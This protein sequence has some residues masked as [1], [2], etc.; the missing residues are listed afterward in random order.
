MKSIHRALPLIVAVMTCMSL[1]SCNFDR[2]LS[3]LSWLGFHVSEN[4]EQPEKSDE[5][6]TVDTMVA[7]GVDV[8][9]AAANVAEVAQST[10]ATPSGDIELEGKINGKYGVHMELDLD[11][12][13]GSYYYT[14]YGDDNS[15]TLSVDRAQDLGNGRMSV[16]LDE[17]A[18]GVYNG[19]FDGILDASSYVGTYTNA[20]GKSMSFSLDVE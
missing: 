11:D 20:Q 14:K 18:N 3:S 4:S 15:L 1:T 7:P 17:Y 16:S 10:P 13:D 12:G 9:E 5:E 8:A 19:N 6:E 2:A